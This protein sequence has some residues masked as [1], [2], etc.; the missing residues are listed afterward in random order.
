MMQVQVTSDGALRL[1]V[2]GDCFVRIPSSLDSLYLVIDSNN[3]ARQVPVRQLLLIEN[4]LDGLIFNWPRTLVS[5][6]AVV[7][8]ETTT[9]SSGLYA[10]YL[11]TFDGRLYVAP[12]DWPPAPIPVANLDASVITSGVFDP[13]RLPVA[14]LTTIGGV[15]RNTGLVGQAVT[16]IDAF[17]NLVY[18]YVGSG[19]RRA[20]SSGNYVYC[21]QAPIGSAENALVW[22]IRRLAYSSGTY[23]ST[24]SASGVDWTNRLT[25]TYL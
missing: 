1:P 2:S 15:K 13:A 22:T 16:A 23:L 11:V 5:A 25:H 19:E 9:L 14:G 24:T 17:G 6:G 18:S 20:S 21:G 7:T 12:V 10:F 8:N 4:N 3:Q